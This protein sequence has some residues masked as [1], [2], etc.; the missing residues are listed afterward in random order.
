M[1][2]FALAA[3]VA[4][5]P[6]E[7]GDVGVEVFASSAVVTWGTD[8]PAAGQAEWAEGGG[9]FTGRA[10]STLPRGTAHR[11]VLSGLRAGASYR[12]RVSGAIGRAETV[13][14]E[15][16]FAVPALPA[17]AD[18]APPSVVLMS[19]APGAVLSG[20]A[21]VSANAV[22]DTGV[23]SVFFLV[24]G[25][26][27]GPG[28]SSA[29]YSARWDTSMSTEGVHALSALA[30]DAAG[31][32]STSAAVSV[33][34]DRSSPVLSYITA[35]GVSP[36]AALVRWTTDDRS[37]AA[38][39][40]GTTTALGLVARAPPGALVAHA[41]ALTG[42]VP[43]AQYFFRVVSADLAGNRSASPVGVLSSPAVDGTAPSAAAPAA[44]EEET[45]RAPQR[46]LTP[47]LADGVNDAAAF[48]PSAREVRIFD[49][50]GR[51]V[52]E[53]TSDSPARPVVWNARDGSGRPL[54]SGVYVAVVVTR[55]GARFSQRIAI[56]K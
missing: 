36:G 23:A 45:A 4:A 7:L 13:S 44:S 50:K 14:S 26:P 54:Q 2:A 38:V 28:I 5:A 9:T 39:E 41:V 3:A 56:A 37:D 19:P 49:L 51:R 15:Y 34:V 40:N 20:A 18:A 55:S 43:G 32:V 29:P 46:I 22:D 1:L 48:G 30:S 17:R 33:S 8:R 53:S 25:Q 10:S 47:A 31:N 42:L 27:I 35:A 6:P 16:S 21:V 12:Y 52:F 11:A 24:D